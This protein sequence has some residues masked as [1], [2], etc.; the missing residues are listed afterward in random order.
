VEEE[1]E[2][3][4]QPLRQGKSHV[5]PDTNPSTII[6]DAGKTLLIHSLDRSFVKFVIEPGAG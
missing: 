2:W 6:P 5:L 4:L 1:V 3:E